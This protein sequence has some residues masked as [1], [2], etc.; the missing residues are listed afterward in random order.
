MRSSGAVKLPLLTG[1]LALRPFEI[2]DAEQIHAVVYGDAEVMRHIG[3]ARDEAHTRAQV[4]RYITVHESH[5]CSFWPVLDRET[6]LIVGEAGLMRFGGVGPDL[7]LGYTFG[8]EFWG[9]GYATEV[10][11]ALIAAAFARDPGLSR[12][13]ALTAPANAGS[14]HVLDKLG[15]VESGRVHASGADQLLYA[16]ARPATVQPQADPLLP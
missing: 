4:E 15:F 11:T 7:E 14:R 6:G 3:G 8:R 16:I 13:V 2:D 12:I 5:G 1:R 9:R 10:G